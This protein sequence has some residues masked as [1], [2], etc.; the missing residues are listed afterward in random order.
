MANEA[1]ADE[2]ATPFHSVQR[3]VSEWAKEEDAELM[4]E[5]YVAMEEQLRLSEPS[6]AR[7]RSGNADAMRRRSS[8]E[9]AGCSPYYV[10]HREDRLGR[11]RRASHQ[12]SGR[13]SRQSSETSG[14][15]SGDPGVPQRPLV[16]T[17]TVS[18]SLTV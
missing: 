2:P 15:E 3:S 16:T 17:V 5:L 6:P 12:D 11:A 10:A 4:R 13:V 1:G 9:G 18:Q 14:S 8:G 7:P